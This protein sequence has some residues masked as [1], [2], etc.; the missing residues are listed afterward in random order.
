MEKLPQKDHSIIKQYGQKMSF[1]GNALCGLLHSQPQKDVLL[2]AASAL[3]TKLR[4]QTVMVFWPQ[5]C[6]QMLFLKVTVIICKHAD[7]IVILTKE[8]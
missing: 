4:W 8:F 6:T 1:P 5:M 3:A 7:L 2:K